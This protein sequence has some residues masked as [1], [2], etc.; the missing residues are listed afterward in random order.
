[1]IVMKYYVENITFDNVC[2]AEKV[3]KLSSVLLLCLVLN[4][5]CVTDVS[6]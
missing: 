2:F 3:T 4:L 5:F 1:M 6:F